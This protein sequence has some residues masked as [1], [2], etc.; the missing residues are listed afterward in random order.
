[1]TTFLYDTARN[2]APAGLLVAIERRWRT[3]PGQ[4]FAG[5]VAGHATAV[6]AVRVWSRS[7]AGAER[8]VP[9]AVIEEVG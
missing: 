4:L 3:R 5:Y 7:G 9:E 6:A 8:R 2:L 1:M